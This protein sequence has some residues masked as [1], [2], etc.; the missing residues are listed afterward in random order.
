MRCASAKPER[1]CI[2]LVARRVW[3]YQREE[4]FPRNRAKHQK[5]CYYNRKVGHPSIAGL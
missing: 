4:E 2:A 3:I 1:D 5:Y